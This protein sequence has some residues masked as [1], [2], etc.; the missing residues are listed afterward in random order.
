[1]P[2]PRRRG[3][4]KR[5]F[6]SD[7]LSQLLGFSLFHWPRSR[8]DVLWQQLEEAW[9]VL[10]DELAHYHMQE[11]GSVSEDARYGFRAPEGPGHRPWGWWEF[12]APEPR[13]REEPEAD[14]LLRLG[15]LTAEE[16]VALGKE[17]TALRKA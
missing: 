1:M 8:G 12:D 7:L 3:R 15:M 6:D 4:Q 9:A 11:P 10:G 2:R 13:N 16:Q 14:Q 17:P 5:E